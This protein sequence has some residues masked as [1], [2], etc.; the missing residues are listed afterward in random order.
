MD[1]ETA[2]GAQKR[3]SAQQPVSTGRRIVNAIR[4]VVLVVVIALVVAT[5]IKTFL[6]QT[7]VIPSVSMEN[8]LNVADRVTVLKVTKFQR[9]DV[10]VF[11]DRLGWLP[12]EAPPGP[13]QKGL[14]FVGLLPASGNQYL[15]KRLVGLPGDHVECCDA[16][17]R[18]LVNGQPIDESAYLYRDAGGQRAAPSLMK[19]SVVVPDGRI[20]VLGDHRDQ[21]ADS[22]YHLCDTVSGDT[23][24]PPMAAIQGPVKVLLYPFDRLRTFDVPAT[25]ASVPAGGTPPAHPVVTGGC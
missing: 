9:G 24:F 23:A 3:P 15:V 13:V 20:F 19:F 6:A 10:I 22:R 11:E 8:T 2:A 16:A 5:L 12:P 17:G 21:S 18:V 14:E 4:E 25:F 7:Y 1:D